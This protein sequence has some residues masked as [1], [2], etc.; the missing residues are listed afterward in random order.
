ME[1]GRFFACILVR[2][3]TQDT[4]GD[5]YKGPEE[6]LDIAM[7]AALEELN[8]SELILIAVMLRWRRSL[9]WSGPRHGLR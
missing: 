3:R 9:P 8:T 1:T 7:L 2:A 4:H 6:A 5:L